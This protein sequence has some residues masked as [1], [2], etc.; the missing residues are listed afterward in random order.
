M[1]LISR[2]AIW[3]FTAFWIWLGFSLLFRRLRVPYASIVAAA[4][5]WIG[6]GLLATW[7]LPPVT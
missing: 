2:I 4:L 7:L 3:A 1:E 5:G 6:A